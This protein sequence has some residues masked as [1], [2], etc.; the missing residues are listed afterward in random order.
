MLQNYSNSHSK[1]GE[2]RGGWIDVID[3]LYKT[4]II[5]DEERDIYFFD[6]IE[7]EF[8]FPKSR[9]RKKEF[10]IE[11]K[12]IG[13]IHITETIPNLDTYKNFSFSLDDLLINKCFIKNL[14]NCIGLITFASN[15]RDK[16]I[17]YNLNVPVIFLKHPIDQNN[18]IKFNLN[19]FQNNLNKNV[20]LLGQQLRKFTSIYKLKTKYEKKIFPGTKKYF[21]HIR[22]KTREEAKF[23]NY[24][25]NVDSI[26]MIY[27]DKYKDYDNML[28]SNIIFMDMFDTGANNAVLECIARNIPFFINRV[29]GIFDYLGYD[30]PMYFNKLSEVEDI[31]NDNA[32]L[33]KLYS[34]TF[35]YLQNMDKTDIS[36]DFFS[37][38][39]KEFIKNPEY[40]NSINL[41]AIY[42]PQF[43]NIKE[44]NIIFYDNY[45]DYKNLLAYNKEIKDIN[46]KYCFE[47]NIKEKIII[48]HNKLF[49]KLD[50]PD[51]DFYD[52]DDYDLNNQN[53]INKQINIAKMNN[54][55]GFAVYYYWFSHNSITKKNMIMKDVIDLFFNSQCN[56]YNIYFIWAN[57]AW[58]NNNYFNNAKDKISNNYSNYNINL[59]FNSLIK[60][61]KHD[62]Y[63]KINNKPVFFIHQIKNEIISSTITKI[64]MIATYICKKNGFNG[65]N[66]V[67]KNTNNTN[68]D[69]PSYINSLSFKAANKGN[70]IY[71]NKDNNKINKKKVVFDMNDK[72][73]NNKKNVINTLSYRFTNLARMFKPYKDTYWISIGEDDKYDNSNKQIISYYN[74][75]SRDSLHKILNINAW[76]EW[77][78]N[79]VIEPG[80]NNKLKYINKIN[81]LIMK[82]K[83]LIIEDGIINTNLSL[84]IDYIY[85]FYNLNFI[86]KTTLILNIEEVSLD[87][88]EIIDNWIGIIHS[89]NKNYLDSIRNM[90]NCVGI[91]YYYKNANILKN[92]KFFNKIIYS[93]K[94]SG[95][96]FIKEVTRILKSQK[97]IYFL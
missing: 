73:I 84:I 86:K 24:K 66:I 21:K 17:S 28:V 62:N 16:I 38:S 81:S 7:S 75:S 77:G 26:E 30:Y 60:Y 43:H 14:K 54:I 11:K 36:L 91:F 31:L 90:D 61:F 64:N 69:L 89:E 47:N 8:I 45:N 33:Y 68:N 96:N 53:L 94:L 95:Y 40:Y 71:Y 48:E 56:K 1:N 76:N 29:G 35:F 32:K 55:K 49:K 82:S 65:I 3:H 50:T 15:I 57:S 10:I 41:F 78:E 46:K 12:W 39:I 80:T 9:S 87:K 23:F 25:I 4:N 97:I 83:L 22:N 34:K 42:F 51:L 19:K 18:L 52:I 67:I 59:M 88:L 72:Y 37:Y 93:D 27:L 20:I 58:S 6:I 79:Y 5:T 85:S 44:N 63:Y 92:S 74:N 70:M 13:M 2:W